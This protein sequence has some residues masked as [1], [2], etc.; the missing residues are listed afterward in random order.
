MDHIIVNKSLGEHRSVDR[1]EHR[2]SSMEIDRCAQK[3]GTIDFC[4]RPSSAA[5]TASVND[6]PC[7]QAEKFQTAW[8]V[9][10]ILQNSANYR[11]KLQT[12]VILHIKS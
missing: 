12:E 4:L 9:G 1:C 5:Q 3:T 6:T 8:T 11:S 2:T 10:G 7:F